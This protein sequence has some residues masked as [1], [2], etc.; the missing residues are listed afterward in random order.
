MTKSYLC[1]GC[2]LENTS[3]GYTQLLDPG[4]SGV[5][6]YSGPASPTELEVG[7]PLV[8]SSGLLL[9][10]TLSRGGI[11]LADHGRV[12]AVRCQPADGTL[13]PEIVKYCH[14]R[15][16]KSNFTFKPKVIVAMGQEALVALTGTDQDILD[17]RGYAIWDQ[18]R[19]CWIMPTVHPDFL[20]AGHSD[21]GAVLLSDVQRALVLREMAPDSMKRYYRYTLDPTES[22]TWNWIKG[23]VNAIKLFPTLK[24]AFDI[25]TPWKSDDEGESDY[26]DLGEHQKRIDRISFAYYGGQAIS[27]DYTLPWAKEVV[28]YLLGLPCEKVVWNEGFDVPILK[29]HGHKFNGII[30]DGM[31]MWHVLHPGLPKKLGFAA[32]MLLPKQERW[33]HLSHTNPAFYNATDSD[34]ELQ[35]VEEITRQLQAEGRWQT[36]QEQIM[37]VNVPLV[38]MGNQG[39]PVNPDKRM[40]AAGKLNVLLAENFSKVQAVT[41]YD[42]LRRTKA[43]KPKKLDEGDTRVKMLALKKVKRC[44]NCRQWPVT[45]TKHTKKQCPSHDPKIV[46]DVATVEV[47]AVRYAFNANSPKQ[48]LEYM[49]FRNHRPIMRGR[50]PKPTTDEKAIK[51]LMARHP[52]DKLYPL[53]LERRKQE[54]LAGTY[55]GRLD[56]SGKLVGGIK[57]DKDNLVHTTFSHNPSTLRLASQDPNLHNMPRPE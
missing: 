16:E 25:E 5:L 17:M 57:M 12:A 46:E 47:D 54:K 42:A 37:Y 7:L 15:H 1:Q 3:S 55:V 48:I 51:Q 31:I 24:L 26:D 33:K 29:S 11:R 34:V 23:L 21:Y 39:M 6:F 45:K 32:S 20:R 52:E 43:T 30:H 18:Q 2:Q 50:P 41:D 40:E 13:T 38:Y 36:Y 14:S 9:D 49:K 28:D 35:C 8:G 44:E 27:F 53:I 19:N 4:V 10:R 56:E 22:E